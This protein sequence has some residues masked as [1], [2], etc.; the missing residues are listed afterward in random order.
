[1]NFFSQMWNWNK[2]KNR[3]YYQEIHTKIES[4]KDNSCSFILF[5]FNFHFFSSIHCRLILNSSLFWHSWLFN[6]VIPSDQ[7]IFCIEDQKVRQ[8]ILEIRNCFH[9][10]SL[11][12]IK[13]FR[14][15][16]VFRITFDKIE[17]FRILCQ[18]LCVFIIGENHTKTWIRDIKLISQ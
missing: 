11:I 15:I 14:W 13:N 6:D 16:D 4:G 2:T 17:H 1:M 3:R 7:M 10:Y 18:K 12:C 5:D 8:S 9:F